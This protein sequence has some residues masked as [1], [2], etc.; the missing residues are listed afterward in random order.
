LEWTWKRVSRRVRVP[1]GR[2]LRTIPKPDGYLDLHFLMRWGASDTSDWP[3]DEPLNRGTID[4]IPMMN[5]VE[6]ET[7]VTVLFEAS[8]KGQ[9]R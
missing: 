5:K 2:A 1:S 4:Q 7:E 6:A 9:R 8:R 3:S